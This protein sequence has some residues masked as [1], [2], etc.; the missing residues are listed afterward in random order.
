MENYGDKYVLSSGRE[1]YANLGILGIDPRGDVSEGYDGGLYPER[2]GGADD[3]TPEER[4]EIA[5][6]AIAAWEKFAAEGR[7]PAEF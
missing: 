3:F 7:P 1:F 2:G 6:F 4:R 5:D